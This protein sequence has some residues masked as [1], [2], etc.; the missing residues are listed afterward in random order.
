M[1]QYSENEKKHLDKKLHLRK[2]FGMVL[3][4][5]CYIG[6]SSNGRK[7]DSESGNEGSTPSRPALKTTEVNNARNIKPKKE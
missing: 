6:P 1:D 7:L 5:L 3:C 4:R 2:L